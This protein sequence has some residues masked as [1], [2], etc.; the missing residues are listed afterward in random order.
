MKN[1]AT[2]ES[3]AFTKKFNRSRIFK[4]AH[5]LVKE[6]G[7]MGMTFSQALSQSWKESKTSMEND[8]TEWSYGVSKL[9][10]MWDVKPLT[11]INDSIQK[12]FEGGSKI[13][14]YEG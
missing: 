8:I 14:G 5:W 6:N 10:S 12:A 7:W 4:R 11:N 1:V 13:L 3:K 9:K 2:K